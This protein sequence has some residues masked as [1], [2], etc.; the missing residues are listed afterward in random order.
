MSED[1]FEKEVLRRVERSRSGYRALCATVDLLGVT[2]MLEEDPYEAMSRLNDL[3][4]SLAN[5]TL[6]FPNDAEERA[7]FAGDS[8]FLVRE[9]GPDEDE[10]Q[11]WRA[12]CG[13]VF[14]LVSMAAEIEHDL[15]NPGIRVIASRGRL[16]Q[17]VELERWREDFIEDQT[18]HWFVLTGAA[19]GLI[20]CQA[21]E[22]AG[23]GG[24]FGRGLFWHEKLD[25]E[26]EYIGTP[27]GKINRQ[28]Y[29]DPTVY[30]Q[31]YDEMCSRGVD[32]ARLSSGYLR[33]D[34]GTK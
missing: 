11:L 20:K 25:T 30:P 22:K 6:F 27:L 15:G 16:V 12:F 8:W 19:E 28:S 26:L 5:A 21:A 23:S 18:R 13:R 31:I 2:R 33:K 7:C 4:Q 3:Q 34:T 14:A 1:D 29:C 17:I 32:T 24:G 9:V 10:A